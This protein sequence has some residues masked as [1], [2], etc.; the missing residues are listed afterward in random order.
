MPL[1]PPSDLRHRTH[2]P[3]TVWFWAIWLVATDKRGISAVQLEN[4]LGISYESACHLL[5]CIRAAIGQRDAQYLL[6][7]IIEMDD[8]YVGGPCHGGKRGRGREKA[9]VVAALSKT[10]QDITLFLRLKV[11]PNIQNQ[12][13]QEIIAACF[14]K[15]MVVECDSYKSYLEPEECGSPGEKVHHRR[16]TLA[17]HRSE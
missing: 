6:S 4:T 2:L 15:N 1:L 13:R 11:V 8:G 16:S 12:T 7:G 3:L 17:P 5:D 9:Q 14:E 10:E